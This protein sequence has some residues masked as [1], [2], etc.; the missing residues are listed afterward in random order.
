MYSR[1]QE[2]RPSDGIFLIKWV[3]VNQ[4][5]GVFIIKNEFK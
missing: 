4:N 1:T 2:V 5:Q 3:D